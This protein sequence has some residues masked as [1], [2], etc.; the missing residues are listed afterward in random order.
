MCLTFGKIPFEDKRVSYE[1]LY[2]AGV[3]TFGTYPALEVNGR[4]I[5]QTQAMARYAGHVSG[6]YPA[7]PWLG[8][9]VDEM[10]DALTDATFCITKTQ[11][12]RNMEVKAQV[13]AEMMRPGGKLNNILI[14]L[15]SL[16]VQNGRIGLCAGNAVSVGDF[17]AWR[18]INWLCSGIVIGVDPDMFDKCFPELVRLYCRIDEMPWVQDWK[19]RYPEF[20]ETPEARWKSWRPYSPAPFLMNNKDVPFHMRHLPIQGA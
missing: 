6:F 18:F 5:N 2:G 20:Y 10:I 8:A 13:R 11:D 3:L 17:A 7:D 9:K 12:I 14:G 19:R 1:E 16:L 4:P 15:N